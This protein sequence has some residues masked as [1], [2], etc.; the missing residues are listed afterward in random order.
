MS[1]WIK[2]ESNTNPKWDFEKDKELMGTL[3]S[4]ETEVG[5]NNSNL[6]TIKKA[7]DSIVSVWG[8]TLLDDRFKKIEIGTEI[9]LVYLGKTQSEKTGRTYHNFDFFVAEDDSVE[10]DSV[11]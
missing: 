6:Y 4:I 8:T 7:D 1:K 2:K 11:D 5:P 10:K 3:V 9:K